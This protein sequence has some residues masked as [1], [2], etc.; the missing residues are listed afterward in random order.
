M[1]YEKNEQTVEPYEL[2][3]DE[4]GDSILKTPEPFLT[5]ASDATLKKAIKGFSMTT[6]RYYPLGK[7][8]ACSRKGG[9]FFNVKKHYVQVY[10]LK[11]GDVLE[12]LICKTG[13]T[14]A[15]SLKRLGS[16]LLIQHKKE[17]GL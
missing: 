5:I 13:E 12:I 17:L 1:E 14:K 2:S 3:F 11:E 16:P 4:N 7:M 10:E 15:K 9:L 6:Q 8:K